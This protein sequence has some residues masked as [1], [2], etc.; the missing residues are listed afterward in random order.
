MTL[1]PQ[2]WA[3][4]VL[5]ALCIGLSKTGLGGFGMLG[6]ALF[7]QVL[8][9]RVSTGYVL[10]LLICAD[11]VAV[12]AFRRHAV[13]KHILRMFVPA[14][15]GILIGFFALKTPLLK[16]NENVKMLIGA[17]VTALILFTYYRRWAQA[18]QP[19]EPKAI[20]TPSAT[21]DAHVHSPLAVMGI[22]LLAGFLT[23]VANASGPVMTLYLLAI[24]L[25]KME[26]IGTGAYYFLILNCF[27][28]PFSAGLGLIT[29][30]SLA[31]DAAVAPAAIA[32]ALWG[33]W[34]IGF[35]NQKLFENLALLFALLSG[36]NLLLTPLITRALHHN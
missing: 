18:R 7:A 32:G 25:P 26:F 9:A 36:L 21:A 34:L 8:P 11:I 14:A 2:E 10:P 16:S 31:F 15:T 13:W 1:S 24:G 4:A 27:K 3:L 22:G 35:L 23:M 28:V 19:V 33:K 12:T 5:G 6:V 29:L 20:D 17:I 30:P